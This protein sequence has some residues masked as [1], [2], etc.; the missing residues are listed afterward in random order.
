MSSS[1][2]RFCVVVAC[3]GLFA[4]L[5]F[6]Q[7]ATQQSQVQAKEIKIAAPAVPDAPATRPSGPPSEFDGLTLPR[8][9]DAQKLIAAAEDLIKES[10]QKPDS[11]QWV[12]AARALQSLLDAP[13]DAFVQMKRKGPDGKLV[14][15]WVSIRAEANRLLGSMPPEGLEFYEI[16]YGP[17]ANSLLSEAKSKGDVLIL[18]AVAQRYLHTK[19][20]EK[21]TSYLAT[22]HL[23]R[24]RYLMAALCFER[25]V[26]RQGADKLDDRTLF[27]A[28]LAFRRAGDQGRA[29]RVWQQLASRIGRQ[30]MKIG[31]QVV[32]AA[33]LR[34]EL[35]RGTEGAET[36]SKH[37][38]PY[39][40]GDPPRTV[41]GY[42]GPP[43]L[44]EPRW[45]VSTLPPEG[46]DARKWL[47]D[48]VLK[49]A[50]GK[51]T[52]NELGKR[53]KKMIK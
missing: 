9:P 36:I 53:R 41:Q 49:A 11:P 39:F 19:A 24:R 51:K 14:G 42:G 12:E 2:R 27:K 18:G 15:H 34:R 38:T 17:P 4:A 26:D 48:T 33:Q 50:L 29:D 35:D 22:Y 32:S 40:R 10:L 6:L 47:E 30:G 5:T 23:D 43:F 28:A 7:T 52:K 21:A 8:N 16:R 37:E 3:G 45:T 44:G 46:D 25:L 20:G 1:I 31:D 13:A